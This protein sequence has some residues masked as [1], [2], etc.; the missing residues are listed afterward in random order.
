VV[1]YR[2][3][4]GKHLFSHSGFGRYLSP[5]LSTFD[6]LAVVAAARKQFKGALRTATCL[7][8][9]LSWEG[10]ADMKHSLIA[11]TVTI[12][13]ALPLAATAQDD[14]R[15]EQVRFAAGT[16]GTTINDSITGYESVLYTVGAEAGQQM[17]VRLEPSNTATYF[18]VYAPGNGPGDEALVNSQFIGPMVPELNIFDA[19][20]PVSGEY[21]VSVY[22]M[23]NA[24]RRDETSNYMIAIS[25]EGDTG[26]TVQADYADGLQ[27]GPDFY[28]VATSGGG[29]LNLRGNP[30]SGADV[31]TRLNNG[32]NLRNLGCRMTEGR[33]WC[34]VATLADPGYKGWAAGDFLI[35]GSNDPS[36]GTRS[37]SPS[38]ASS[39]AGSGDGSST[40]VVKF[41]SGSSGTELT[42]SLA[43]GEARRYV[44][45]A[46]SGQNLYV[47]VAAQGKDTY[48]QIFNPDNSFLLDQVSSSQEYRGQ[49]W[50]SGDHVIEVINRGG[51]TSPY[52]VIFGIE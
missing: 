11:F 42:G 14:M 33:R 46:A 51:S 40:V 23:R 52:N 37:A 13:L 24:A 1:I 26:A 27:G 34:R 44:L 31:V 7:W 17:K 2:E 35:E 3:W 28:R 43:P 38:S 41:P 47:R 22:M 6:G 10:L 30:S 18:N 50:Q 39:A 49:L 48:Y 25:I 32:Q 5:K 20:L 4:Q 8:T 12:A 9:T 16:S 36:A 45:G 15:T 19:E 29:S 21:A